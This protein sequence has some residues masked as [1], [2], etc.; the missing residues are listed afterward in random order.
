MARRQQGRGAV[1]RA[2]SAASG[3]KDLARARSRSTPHPAPRPLSQPLPHSPSSSQA[4]AVS[5]A[6]HR[7]DLRPR[8]PFSPARP[9]SGSLRQLR[10]RRTCQRGAAAQQRPGCPRD[11][12][13]RR[14]SL[15]TAGQAAL[16]A[17]A[18]HAV[19]RCCQL[20]VKA[21]LDVFV[22]LVPRLLRLPGPDGLPLQPPGVKAARGLPK[23]LRLLRTATDSDKAVPAMFQYNPR[24]TELCVLLVR[25]D[26]ARGLNATQGEALDAAR[27]AATMLLRRAP[28]SIT[29]EGRTANCAWLDHLARKAAR[30]GVLHSLARRTADAESST[31][32]GARVTLQLA[33]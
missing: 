8:A 26:E 25:G 1:L 33:G 4:R 18:P 10:R 3:P 19:N 27:D 20:K 11:E 12:R 21:A 5:P 23:C 28:T 32:D 15:T 2:G 6:G 17:S 14:P 16:P 30:V 31:W 13:R 22:E 7:P 29:S 9:G 24:V